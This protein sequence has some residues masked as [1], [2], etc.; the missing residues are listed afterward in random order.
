MSHFQVKLSGEWKDY[1]REEDKILK[2]AYM[3]GF[4]K[5]KFQLRGYKYEYDFKRMTQLNKDTKTVRE[6]RPPMRRGKGGSLEE[7]KAPSTPIVPEG[8]TTVINVPPGSPGT[9]IQVPYP[10]KKNKF[11][12]VKVPANAKVGQ[13]MLV[14]VPKDEVASVRA[15][16]SS[17]GLSTGAKIATGGAVLVGVGGMAVGG[18]I[19]GEH[20]AEHGFDATMDGIGDGL[21]DGV[22]AIGDFAVDAGEFI[23]DG[24]E[25]VGDFIM[26]LF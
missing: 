14:P 6:I 8:P 26:D 10:G 12:A 23:V 2:R 13:A 19:L 3:A 7:W 1:S 25:D 16:P 24:A 15:P 9:V 22:E 5:A 17:G 20:I 4:P 21:T 18:A 11:I